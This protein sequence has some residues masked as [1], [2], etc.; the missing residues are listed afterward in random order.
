MCPG[1]IQGTVIG[2]ETFNGIV[3]KI[4][5]NV[6]VLFDVPTSLTTQCHVKFI[7][8]VFIFLSA[9]ETNIGENKLKSVVGISTEY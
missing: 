9:K 6:L 8:L 4:K 2:L 5:V 1:N 3:P 7:K